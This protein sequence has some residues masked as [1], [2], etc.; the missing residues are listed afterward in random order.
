MQ[1]AHLWKVVVPILRLAGTEEVDNED[2]DKNITAGVGDLVGTAQDD[3]AGCGQD[4]G[5]IRLNRTKHDEE[6]SYQ[7][8]FS[9]DADPL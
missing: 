2:W 1:D 7:S 5:M 3:D 8:G 4:A 9:G 6:A